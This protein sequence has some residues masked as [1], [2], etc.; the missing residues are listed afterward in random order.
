MTTLGVCSKCVDVTQQTQ[1]ECK[2]QTYS[3]Y[4]GNPLQ[5]RYCYYRLPGSPGN[6]LSVNVEAPNPTVNISVNP[7]P[8]GIVNMTDVN[9][10]DLLTTVMRMG[11]VRWDR[12]AEAEAA[13][14]AQGNSTSWLDTMT[15]QECAFSLCPWSFTDWSY[16]NGALKPG[17]TTQSKFHQPDA[18]LDFGAPEALVFNATDPEFPGNQTFTMSGNDRSAIMITLNSLW[19][20]STGGTASLQLWDSLHEAN[21]N[22]STT[23][24]AMA[25]GMTYNMMNGPNATSALGQVFETQTFIYVHWAWLS[26]AIITVVVSAAILVFTIVKTRA[27]HQRAWK[28]SLVPLLYADLTSSPTEVRKDS[29]GEEHKAKRMERIRTG[30]V[31]PSALGARAGLPS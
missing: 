14:G 19:D 6:P 22:I 1:V 29:W 13:A 30:L 17:S 28:S 18:E 11:I 8:I 5:F 15:A 12:V 31:G 9:D 16:A 27:A 26:L 2:N 23:L 4:Q 21:R 10:G 25:T 24:E 20:A 3:E 7:P